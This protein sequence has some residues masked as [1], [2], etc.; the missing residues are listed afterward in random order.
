[1][2][3]FILVRLSFAE[4]HTAASA[5]A[6]AA[7]S[8]I[9]LYVTT[10]CSGESRAQG[11]SPSRVGNIQVKESG[12][13]GIQGGVKPRSSNISHLEN[14]LR[15]QSLAERCTS[16]ICFGG[17][18]RFLA[19]PRMLLG[20]VVEAAQQAPSDGPCYETGQ[21]ASSA[22]LHT[23]TSPHKLEACVWVVAEIKHGQ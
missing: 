3:C 19:R 4:G 5:D 11:Q 1:M 20:R 23:H 18:C 7:D 14:G 15:I 6:D 10:G 12:G 8:L 17:I 9:L 16:N 21:G 2:K 13:N 22:E